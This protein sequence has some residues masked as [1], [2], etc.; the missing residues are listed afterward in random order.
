[1]KLPVA[2]GRSCEE[3]RGET[4]DDVPP[5][6]VRLRVFDRHHGICWR[7]TRKIA[8]GER[9]QC[10]HVIAVI[11]GGKNWE[12]NLAPL[13]SWCEP[14]KNAEDVAEKSATYK[15]RAKHVG[16]E[17][18]AKRPFSDP[19]LLRKVDGSVVDRATGERVGRRT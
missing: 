16:I 8:A 13:C 18:T 1:M 9:W 3:W 15:T 19:R 5:P 10:D 6:R 7:C 2:V 17:T 4:A 12:S 11:N 14:E